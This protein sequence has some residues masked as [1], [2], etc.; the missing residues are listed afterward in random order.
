MSLN[1]K[2]IIQIVQDLPYNKESFWL[3]MGSAMV[4]WGIKDSTGDIDIGCLK[5]LFDYLL[6]QGFSKQVS[7]S[8]RWRID[9]GSQVHFYLEWS[10]ENLVV[11]NNIQVADINSIVNDKKRFKRSKDIQDLNLIQ[12]Y[13]EGV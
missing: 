3:V 10:V 4:M 2:D 12:D 9:Y 1:R 7:R 11:I 6:E 5:E 8:G 13:L